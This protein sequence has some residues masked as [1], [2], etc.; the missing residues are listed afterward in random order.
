M[1]IVEQIFEDLFDTIPVLTNTDKLSFGYGD[2]KEL[3][4]ILI[5]KQRNGQ[6]CY[7]L[8]WYNLPNTL[9]ANERYVEGNF[10][11][12]IAH[13]T[14]L[15]WFND[16]RFNINF[17]KILYPYFELVITALTKANGITPLYVTGNKKYKYTNYPNY[18]SPSANDGGSEQQQVDAW[19]AIKFTVKLQISSSACDFTNINYKI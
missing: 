9:D 18:G 11:F 3:D 12:V 17:K 7:P 2:K 4:S 1:I 6:I 5:T 16:Q 13:N 8:L 14:Q 19:D 15:D 10:D